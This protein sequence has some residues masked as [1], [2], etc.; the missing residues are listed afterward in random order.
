QKGLF[1]FLPADE[2]MEHLQKA[3]LAAETFFQS[4]VEWHAKQPQP[5][6]FGRPAGGPES[7]RVRGADIVPDGL[8]GQLLIRGTHLNK[9]GENL[10]D[11]QKIEVTSLANRAGYIAASLNQ[12]L[13][14]YLPDQVY[15][16]DITPG[17]SAKIDLCSA[18]IEVGPALQ[19][20]L[21]DKV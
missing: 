11:E 16:M 8:S 15:W 19:K 9:L 12:W 1:V 2:A 6:R 18:P 17:S 10:D 3:R 7:F 14:Q 5:Q 20:M 21:Y 4:L 13:A